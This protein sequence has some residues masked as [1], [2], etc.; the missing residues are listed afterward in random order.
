LEALFVGETCNTPFQEESLMEA[1][2]AR[3]E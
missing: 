1:K 3:E 2:Q